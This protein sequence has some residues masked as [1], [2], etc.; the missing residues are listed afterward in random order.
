MRE[1]AIDLFKMNIVLASGDLGAAT[2]ND[3]KES[4]YFPPEHGYSWLD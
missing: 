2:V 4:T 3:D 1:T